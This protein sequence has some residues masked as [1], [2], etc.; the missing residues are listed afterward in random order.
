M[1]NKI[2]KSCNLFSKQHDVVWQ[3]Q[4]MFYTETFREQWN[5]NIIHSIKKG[6]GKP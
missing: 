4:K 1:L 2:D 3:I 6:N 5:F